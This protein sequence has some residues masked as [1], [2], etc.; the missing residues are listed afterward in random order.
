M[1]GGCWLILSPRAELNGGNVGMLDS[2]Y[3]SSVSRRLCRRPHCCSNSCECGPTWGGCV[4]SCSVWVIKA[5]RWRRPQN[6]KTGQRLSQCAAKW[7]LLTFDFLES[8]QKKS[9]HKRQ[10]TCCRDR[11]CDPVAFFCLIRLELVSHIIRPCI[12]NVTFSDLYF[13]TWTPVDQ[14]QSVII[15][16]NPLQISRKQRI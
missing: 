16:K 11:L 5:R 13:S 15:Q 2:T 9:W 3:V 1:S 8:A 10:Q 6:V 14:P 4:K 12:K 7:L